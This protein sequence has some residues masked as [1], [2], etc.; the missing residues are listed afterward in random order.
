MYLEV[1]LFDD[2]SNRLDLA[3]K[4]RERGSQ[5][6]GSVLPDEARWARHLNSFNTIP[7]GYRMPHVDAG[8][9]WILRSRDVPMLSI[10][11]TNSGQGTPSARLSTFG[12]G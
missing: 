9:P 2:E 7:S 4:P 10:L 5:G 3:N 8:A 12:S 6:G 1:L 11:L